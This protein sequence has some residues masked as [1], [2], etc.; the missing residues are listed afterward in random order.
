MKAS[1]AVY[2]QPPRKVRLVTNLIKG[3]KVADAIAALT[4]LP[5]KAALPVKKLIESAIANAKNKGADVTTLKVQNVTVDNAGM[6]KGMR[7]RAMGRG[8]TIRHRRSQV[9]VTLSQ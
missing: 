6:I 7:P 5:K 2:N 1:L 3:K 4:F 9:S 8:A